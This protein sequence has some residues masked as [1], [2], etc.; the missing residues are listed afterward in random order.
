[1]KKRHTV[2]TTH[3]LRLSVRICDAIINAKAHY[4]NNKQAAAAPI[5]KCEDFVNSY[6]HEADVL[7]QYVETHWLNRTSNG[8]YYIQLL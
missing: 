3:Q 2:Y 1:M 7:L 8:H 5:Q 4:A 6:R